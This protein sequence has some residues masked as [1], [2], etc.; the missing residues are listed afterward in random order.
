MAATRLRRVLLGTLAGGVLWCIWSRIIS[1]VI[2]ESKYKFAMA[3]QL[4]LSQPR[5][6]HFHVYWYPM[7]FILTYIL[8]W[9]YVSARATLGPGPI[10]ALRVGLLVGFAM[11]FPLSLSLAAWAP[12]SRGITLGWML[13]LWVGSMLATLVS[14][15]LYKES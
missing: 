4:M 15:W 6:P 2:L 5:Y 7:L 1:S 13:D 3:H 14:A 10:T 9:V 8:I 11:S 12:F